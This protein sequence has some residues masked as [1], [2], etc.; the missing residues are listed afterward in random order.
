MGHVSYEEAKKTVFKGLVLL[1]LVTIAEVAIALLGKG[2]IISGFYLPKWLVYIA[3]IGLSLYK[4]YFIM[5]E[6]MHLKHEVKAL[7]SSILLPFLLLVWAIIAFLWD[8]ASWAEKRY[9]Y[10]TDFQKERQGIII[11]EAE[12]EEKIK[13]LD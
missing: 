1:A 8:G 5:G 11:D 12:L 10:K 6:F 3:M 13:I 2:Y 7:V 4:A 9:D